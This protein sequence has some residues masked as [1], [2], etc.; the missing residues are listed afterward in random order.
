MKQTLY[1]LLFTLQLTAQSTVISAIHTLVIII[2]SRN[3]FL[4][5]TERNSIP[6]NQFNNIEMKT[7]YPVPDI[8]SEHPNFIVPSRYFFHL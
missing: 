8:F 4:K 7:T 2:Q 6:T 1:L 5:N 3:G